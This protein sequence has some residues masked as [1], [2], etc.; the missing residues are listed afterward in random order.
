M[1]NFLPRLLNKTGILKRINLFSKIVINNKVFYIP[2][3]KK[4]GFNNLF[5]TEIWMV[6]V[7]KR[8]LKLKKGAFIDIGVN[9]GQTL[10]KLRSVDKDR[11]Y[12][13]FEPNPSCVFY[14]EELIK[15]NN[16]KN[17]SVIPVGISDKDEVLPL[18]IYSENNLTDSAASIIED[19]RTQKIHKKIFVPVFSAKTI[20]NVFSNIG[21]IKI[22]VEG[23]ELEVIES[24]KDVL[25]RDRPFVFIEILPS[26]EI[27]N[28]TRI[29]RSD[30][31]VS[32]I[33]ELEYDIYRIIKKPDDSLNEIIKIKEI[34]VHS[35]LNLCDYIFVP[36]EHSH[37]FAQKK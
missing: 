25:S 19:F 17:T 24:F 20:H 31:I 21:F 2:I 10:I 27:S 14:I 7:L 30:K 4:V 23:A 32:I 28:K 35:N 15:K 5:M 3:I 8:F 16:F 11:E 36:K 18:N 34:S 29:D 9:V 26:Y 22:D 1:N 37:N 6:Q 12:I 33:S 13:G